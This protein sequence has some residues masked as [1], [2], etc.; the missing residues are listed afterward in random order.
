MVF[1][2]FEQKR[3]ISPKKIRNSKNLSELV[4]EGFGVLNEI[5]V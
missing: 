1:E 3:I 5:G 2:D 4:S